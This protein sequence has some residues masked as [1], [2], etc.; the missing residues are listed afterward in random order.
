MNLSVGVV[1]YHGLSLNSAST[2]PL[3]VAVAFLAGMGVSFTLNRRYTFDPSG[4]QSTIELRDFFFVSLGGL[5]LTTGLANAFLRGLS[6]NGALMPLSIPVETVA[7]VMAVAITA[8][9]S[10]LA[11]KHVSFRRA[12]HPL[13]ER[14]S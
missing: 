9:Y 4:R 6:A 7:H 8:F 11:H 12:R 13:A 1:L 3:S 2:Y 5:C 10:F 14:R